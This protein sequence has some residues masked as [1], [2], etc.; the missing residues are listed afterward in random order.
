[1]GTPAAMPVPD[2]VA[3]LL[4]GDDPF[5]RYF[6]LTLLG[7]SADGVAAAKTR[8]RF[9]TEGA[10]PLILAAQREEGHRCERERFCT[11][12]TTGTVW[13]LIILAELGADGGDERLRRACEA[14][15]VRSRAGG[16]IGLVYGISTVRKV[17][18]ACL[19]DHAR[20]D[21]LRR[22]GMGQR[23]REDRRRRCAPADRTCP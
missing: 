18:P 10:V 4:D 15:L 23:R 2:S 1:M 22:D 9:M 6:P 20:H 16:V 11:A 13:Q 7:E 5:V 3:W 8:C 14:V 19:D 12:K 17:R 21:G